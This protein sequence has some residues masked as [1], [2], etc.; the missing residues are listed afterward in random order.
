MARWKALAAE[1]G[2]PFS[3]WVR[4]RLDADMPVTR[5]VAKR[6][7]HQPTARG[8]AP[9]SPPPKRADAARSAKP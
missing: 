1:A 7:G 4:Q 6:G 5:P 2:L 8:P 9:T 3:Q